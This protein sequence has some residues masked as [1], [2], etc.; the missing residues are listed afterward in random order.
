MQ[1]LLLRDS[2]RHQHFISDWEV[3]LGKE[4][5]DRAKARGNG[6]A[7]CNRSGVGGRMVVA[8]VIWVDEESR[9]FIQKCDTLNWE[10][11]LREHGWENFFDRAIDLIQL[12]FCDPLDAERVVGPIN[13][14]TQSKTYTYR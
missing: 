8:E 4:V 5:I 3:V 11:Y 13:P 14:A 9:N 12:G 1:Q 7:K 2:P 10:K 6:C